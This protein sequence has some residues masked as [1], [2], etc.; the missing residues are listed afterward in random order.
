MEL[1]STRRELF[2]VKLS[3]VWQA[4]R[5]ERVFVMRLEWD[6]QPDLWHLLSFDCYWDELRTELKMNSMVKPSHCTWTDNVAFHAIYLNYIATNLWS[7]EAA[8]ISPYVSP[9]SPLQYQF[10]SHI[11]MA[12]DVPCYWIPFNTGWIKFFRSKATTFCVLF[13]GRQQR[14]ENNFYISRSH[15]VTRFGMA[16]V[17][18]VRHQIK[19]RREK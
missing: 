15:A 10:R 14:S 5:R 17:L 8:G 9:S 13:L 18:P 1:L 3:E 19:E 6:Q 2:Y 11:G 12:H 7:S 16:F 4:L